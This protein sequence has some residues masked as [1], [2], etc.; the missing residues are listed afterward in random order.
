MEQGR[1]N[2]D[3]LQ[4]TKVGAETVANRAVLL[5]GYLDTRA[6]RRRFLR[7]LRAK[8]RADA[9]LRDG[10][11][12]SGRVLVPGIAMAAA[13]VIVRRYFA[14][15]PAAGEGAAY[16]TG[17]LAA[18]GLP[19]QSARFGQN[20]PRLLAASSAPDERVPEASTFWRNVPL[21]LPG[22]VLAAAVGFC[23][24]WMEEAEATLAGTRVLEALVIALLVGV[25]VRNFGALSEQFL[26]GATF[27][28]KHVLEFAVLLLGATIEIQ[29]VVN[30][31]WYLL[32]AISYG[33]LIGLAASYALGRAF[34]LPSRL[35]YLVAVGNSI[36]GNSA[37]GA[38]A[39]VIKA[40]RDEV[41]SAIGLTAV[42]GVA[43]VVALPLLAGPLHLSDYCYGIVVGMS[44]YA[45]PQVVTAAFAV[46]ELSGQVATLVK[47][48]RVI[49]LGPVVVGTGLYMRLK[50]DHSGTVHRSQ[51]VPWFV[52]GFFALL[53]L[54]SA[55][56]LPDASVSSAGILSRVLTI[57]A[58]A[59]LGLSVDLRALRSVCVRVGATS[60]LSMALLVGLSMFLI[61]W[62]G[63]R[64]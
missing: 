42:A 30:A 60:V 47:L 9:S 1:G 51:V 64:G 57:V 28:S 59:G 34:G 2:A 26:P 33:V 23:G 63:L 12:W 56:A 6:N 10:R 11:W 43:M 62:L 37:I 15:S 48:V 25:C 22:L 54:R 31:G 19:A 35:A 61:S 5:R 46:S 27:A 55:G 16:G 40:E 4:R 8:A 45:V 7:R 13:A 50:G 24:Y 14:A 20:K 21:L 17:A 49:F 53:A 44:V 41:A 3:R 32:A 29:T 52:V 38:V 39:P 36:C 18:P 58:I